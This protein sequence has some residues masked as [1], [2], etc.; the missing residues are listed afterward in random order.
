MQVERRATHEP[1]RRP[2]RR[3]APGA[4]LAALTLT[5]L[6]GGGQSAWAA[7]Q[8]VDRPNVTLPPAPVKLLPFD[9]RLRRVAAAVGV[10]VDDRVFDGARE[11]RLALG[12][13]DFVNGTAPDL[14]WNA[15][16]MATWI[17]AMLPV[18]RDA[19]VRS[20]VGDWKQGGLDKFVQGAFGRASTA[21]DLADLSAALAIS[22]DDGWV[23]ACLSLV[24]SAE[25]VL[26]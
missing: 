19:R 22:G 26:Q 3:A 16:R 17:T 6:A 18:C 10:P 7:P 5:L 4:A 20:Y 9:A 25:M 23:A 14:Q 21:D 2:E 24:T 13:H 11:Q 1:S 8:V 12:A 15:Q